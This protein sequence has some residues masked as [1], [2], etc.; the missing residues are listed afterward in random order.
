MALIEK[1]TNAIY[2]YTNKIKFNPEKTNIIFGITSD[3]RLAYIKS[4]ELRKIS[5]TSNSIPMKIYEQNLVSYD[6]IFKFIFKN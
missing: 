1:E 5:N 2:R 6:D 3:N 4:K